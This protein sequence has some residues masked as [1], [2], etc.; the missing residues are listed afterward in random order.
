M[1]R[2]LIFVG[3]LIWFVADASS[4]TPPSGN[5]NRIAFIVA[6]DPQYLAEA[7]A[8]PQKLDPYSEQANSRAID[9]LNTFS[10]RA[11]AAEQ[12]G[13]RVADEILGLVNTGDLIDSLDKTGGF[14]PAMQRF[15]W[16][17]FK[18][19]Y[20][21]TGR[22][23]K[24]PYPVYEMHGNHDG[25]QGDTFIVNG[26]IERN[27]VRPGVVNRSDNGLHYSWDWGK[28]HCVSLGIFVGEGEER[29]KDYHYAPR[30]SLE[31][32]RQDLEDQVGKSGRPVMLFFHIHPNG[33]EYD[34]P[35]EDLAMFWQA[36]KPYN[37]VAL[38]HG[39]THA[40]PPSRMMWDGN[41]FGDRLENGL[42]VF[43]PDDIG[44]AKIDP[45]EPSKAVGL[46][47]GFLYVEL[48]DAEGTGQ[49]RLVVRSYATNDNW[50]THDWHSTWTIDIA[51]P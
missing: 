24:I 8:S 36:I 17:R 23:G 37:V 21:L 38:F 39:H 51:V 2:S 29:R 10:G 28:L 15:E 14:Y 34:W 43:N 20:G 30:A 18:A 31:F 44:A 45:Q 41:Q 19:D 35:P 33:P 12:G 7:S 47:H 46:P 49:D 25:P 42:N 13:G 22:D 4:D 6:G 3:L 1:K 9:I 48:L 50:A 32:L 40:S 5:T 16:D 27:K 11:I 26:I